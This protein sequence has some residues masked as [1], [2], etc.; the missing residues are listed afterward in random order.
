MNPFAEASSRVQAEEAQLLRRARSGDLSAFNALVDLHQRL[1]YNLCLRML[2][3]RASAEDAAQET[4]IS[5]FRHIDSCHGDRFRPWLL[6]IAANACTD[7][8][9]RR[10]RRPAISL[11]APSPV[12]NTPLDPPDPAAGPED[13]SMRSEQRREIAAALLRLP[14]DQRLAVVL[15]DVHGL[16]YDEIA[17][18][19]GASLGT[20]KSRIARGREKLRRELAA[21]GTFGARTPS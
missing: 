1:V 10:S 19:T 7:E 2:G 5:A 4:F 18:A 12:D 6:R 16:P 17:T 11:D 15:C 13:E 14:E 8:M 9:R 21:R 3:N 20:V